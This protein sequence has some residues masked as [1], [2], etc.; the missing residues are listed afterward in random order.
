MDGQRAATLGA[1][2]A[3]QKAHSLCPA[4]KKM[5]KICVHRT[6]TV[7]R[8]SEEADRIDTFESE[9]INKKFICFAS[10][11]WKPL[12]ADLKWLL[13]EETFQNP[14]DK[15]FPANKKHFFYL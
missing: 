10:S 13:F 3:V 6:R 9:K 1:P 14:K 5:A 8:N 11:F 2:R 7:Y 12:R 15:T 4:Q